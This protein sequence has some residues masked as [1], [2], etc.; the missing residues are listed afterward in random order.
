MSRISIWAKLNKS[1][2]FWILYSN[3]CTRGQWYRTVLDSIVSFRMRKSP[4][5]TN[6]IVFQKVFRILANR[7]AVTGL[8]IPKLAIAHLAHTAHQSSMSQNR[9]HIYASTRRPQALMRPRQSTTSFCSRKPLATNSRASQI[10]R[11]YQLVLS[12]HDHQIHFE[13]EMFSGAWW[14]LL[15]NSQFPASREKLRLGAN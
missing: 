3:R 15:I 4:E 12:L 5:S 11:I 14:M 10:S 1:S 2:W 8:K 7:R 6:R 13:G 9:C